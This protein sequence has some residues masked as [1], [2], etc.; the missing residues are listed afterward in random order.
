MA[1]S[2]VSRGFLTVRFFW[3]F[4]TLLTLSTWQ[5][6]AWAGQLVFWEFNTQRRQL[7]F[8]TNERVQPEAQLI[9]DP[10]RLV[11]DY[12]ALSW[13]ALLSIAAMAAKLRAYG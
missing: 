5:L 12:R 13:E 9:P 10:S 2:L 7:Q 11:I 8:R 6:P 3:F 4:L 1:F